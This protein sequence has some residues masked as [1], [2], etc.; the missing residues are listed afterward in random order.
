VPLSQ[1]DVSQV[2]RFEDGAAWLELRTALTK[3][4]HDTIQDLNS[5]YRI[6]A[7][8]FTGEATVDPD[9]GVE[10]R[11]NAKQIN[12]T[13]FELLAV[14]WSLEEPISAMA[15]DT[16]DGPS[17]EWV[18]NCVAEAIALGRG[19]AEGNGRSTVRP[20][21]SR[22]TSRGAKRSNSKTSPRPSDD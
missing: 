20:K 9:A 10:V 19:R 21:S 22:S 17:G 4:D 6:P 16:L 7:S 15:Y 8:T 3:G 5:H 18:D 2:H 12:R 14:A 1:A 13:L 11:T